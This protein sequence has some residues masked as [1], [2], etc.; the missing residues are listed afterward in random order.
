MKL[1]NLLSSPIYIESIIPPYKPIL[2]FCEDI[3]LVVVLVEFD[4][5]LSTY[6]PIIFSCCSLPF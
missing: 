3:M 1:L 4:D 6:V 2:T 5:C